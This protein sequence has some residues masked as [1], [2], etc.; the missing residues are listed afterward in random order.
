MRDWLQRAFVNA[1]MPV[2]S[3]TV[4]HFEAGQAGHQK[5][6]PAV[7]KA[8]RRRARRKQEATAVRPPGEAAEQD[9]MFKVRRECFA[10][11]AD[12]HPTL[13]SARRCGGSRKQWPSAHPARSAATGHHVR[14][15]LA[16]TIVSTNSASAD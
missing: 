8:L 13:M 14:G 6:D 15:A 16:Y 10:F 7:R 1:V 12:R 5:L 3:A 2:V 9:T 11:G 4:R